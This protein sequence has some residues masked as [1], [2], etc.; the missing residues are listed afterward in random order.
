LS[1][2]EGIVMRFTTLAYFAAA[3]S[4]SCLAA[5]AQATLVADFELNGSL[6]NS[7][8]TAA[9]LTN[10]GATQTA[11][12]LDFAINKGPTL[13]GL[14]ALAAYTIDMSF[15]LDALN[16]PRGNGY[17]KLID[18]S[19]LIDDRGYYSHNNG[20]LNSYPLSDSTDPVFTAGQPVRLT[21]SRDTAGLITAHIDNALIYSQPDADNRSLTAIDGLNPL[22]FF[23]DDV[24]TAFGEASSGSVDYIRIFDTAITP[25]EAN[26]APSAV[27]EP[28]TWA[29]FIGGFGLVGG[30]MRR[31]GKLAIA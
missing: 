15:T 6:V 3:V 8:G 4:A 21:L 30:A 18:F 28:A 19:S 12:G 23:Q 24:A 5:A 10:N 26:P 31:R 2:F 27:P 17:I 11:T 22:T 13:S 20:H 7:A 25:G 29:M 14:G 16:G 9:T 1:G